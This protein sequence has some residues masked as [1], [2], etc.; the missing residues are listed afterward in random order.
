MKAI[1]EVNKQP[2]QLVATSSWNSDFE[3]RGGDDVFGIMHWDR[4]LTP[5]VTAQAT[6]GRWTFFRSASGQQITVTDTDSDRHIAD[7]RSSIVNNGELVFPD[8]N[9]FKWRSRGIFGISWEWKH[10][11]DTPILR[12]TSILSLKTEAQIRIQPSASSLP[13]LSLLALLGG[14]LMFFVNGGG[15]PVPRWI[16]S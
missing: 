3:L 14:Y 9:R 5:F 16:A 1:S 4:G 13:E 12:V 15:L 8:G 2:L 7:Y 11:N 6:D 10:T